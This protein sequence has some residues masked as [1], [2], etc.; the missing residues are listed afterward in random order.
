MTDEPGLPP[1]MSPLH[2]RLLWFIDGGTVVIAC[3]SAGLAIGLHHNVLTPLTWTFALVGQIAARRV[4]YQI[5][6]RW[7][8]IAEIHE[9]KFQMLMEAMHR[10]IA[11]GIQASFAEGPEDKRPSVH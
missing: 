10:G 5:A 6:A 2:R 9:Q 4:A 3:G 8:R 7:R 1:I 11:V